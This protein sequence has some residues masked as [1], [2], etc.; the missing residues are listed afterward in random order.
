MSI[1]SHSLYNITILIILDH[2]IVYFWETEK[3]VAALAAAANVHHRI[4]RQISIRIVNSNF[5]WA[6][7]FRRVHRP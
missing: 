7:R 1:I 2:L 3:P 6:L 4:E 5:E